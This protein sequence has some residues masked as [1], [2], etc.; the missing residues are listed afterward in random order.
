MKIDAVIPWV[1][2]NDATLSAKRNSYLLPEER[3]NEDIAGSTRFTSVGEI[4]YCVT[5]LLKFAPFLNKIYIVSDG[6]DPKIDNPKVEVI[7]H[8]TIFKGYEDKLP[9]FN[10]NSIETLIWNIPSL[11]EHFIYLN[12]DFFLVSPVTE[13]DFFPNGKLNCFG[14]WYSVALYRFE[15]FIKPKKHGAGHVGFKDFMVNGLDLV[16]G[17]N[18]FIYLAHSPRPLL[19]SW[20]ENFCANHPEA[21]ERN[22]KDRFRSADQWQTQE[23]FLY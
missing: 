12:D 6:Q 11:S 16:G 18:K 19:K 10:S 3:E 23:S 4:Y 17:G 2:G 22:L 1:D 13:Q 14:D 20:F 5:S 8:K 15:R 21:V 9:V 7:D